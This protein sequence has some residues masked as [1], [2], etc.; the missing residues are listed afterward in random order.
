MLSTWI[1]PIEGDRWSVEGSNRV[2]RSAGT[3]RSS[4]R[5]TQMSWHTHAGIDAICQLMLIW[6]EHV[7]DCGCL[8]DI[9]Q[10]SMN[11]R[12][13]SVQRGCCYCCSS[14]PHQRRYSYSKFRIKKGMMPLTHTHTHT[15]H[16]WIRSVFFQSKR[17]FSLL[18]MKKGPFSFF[19]LCEEMSRP[20]LPPK[21]ASENQH[22]LYTCSRNVHIITISLEDEQE[23]SDRRV[24]ERWFLYQ[25][26][27][28]IFL[29]T[30]LRHIYLRTL[31]MDLQPARQFD[32]LQRTLSIFLTRASNM[33]E[34]FESLI[35]ELIKEN[36]LSNQSPKVRSFLRRTTSISI[37]FFTLEFSW[38]LLL[39][40]QV[41][42]AIGEQLASA[43]TGEWPILS[44]RPKLSFSVC[45]KKRSA[46]IAGN[47]KPPPSKRLKSTTPIKDEDDE[48]VP[49]NS[50]KKKA[51]SEEKLTPDDDDEEETNDD[52]EEIKAKPSESRDMDE[53]AIQ[54]GLVCNKCM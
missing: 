16:G 40:F 18:S 49:I 29:H 11:I 30:Y 31:E 46:P 41:R 25:S 10:V 51:T 53:F 47:S 15:W 48:I 2:W 7:N 37:R 33:S 50:K 24:T 36:K 54:L 3:G 43:I 8:L 21:F 5:H 39:R 6:D 38:I 32:Y 1:G 42:C 14:P 9:Q 17:S 19:C 45:Q 44:I 27:F 34:Q 35:E 13:T 20:F 28:Q 12:R 22:P 4:A 26:I 23:P 52:D